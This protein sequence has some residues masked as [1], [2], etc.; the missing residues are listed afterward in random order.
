MQEQLHAMLEEFR[1]WVVE[2]FPAEAGLE[3]EH[4]SLLLAGTRETLLMSVD[5]VQ[6]KVPGVYLSGRQAEMRPDRSCS[7]EVA[8]VDDLLALDR[9]AHNFLERPFSF[10]QDRAVS[11]VLPPRRKTP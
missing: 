2:H 10:G 3:H 11:R 4:K 7:V 5:L 9:F 1:E 6:A 8:L